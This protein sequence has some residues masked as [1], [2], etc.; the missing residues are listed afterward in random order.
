M[1]PLMDLTKPQWRPVSCLRLELV[2]GKTWKKTLEGIAGTAAMTGRSYIDI[3]AIFTTVAG[4][5][6]TY[7]R[8][9]ASVLL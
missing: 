1:E 6:K 7:V 5:G 4:N 2:P 9:V 8:T 3:S